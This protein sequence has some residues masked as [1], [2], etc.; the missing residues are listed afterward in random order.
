VRKGQCQGE[1]HSQG[2]VWKVG[3][4]FHGY[5]VGVRPA[6]KDGHLEIYFCQHK[7][8]TLNLNDPQ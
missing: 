1:L 8:A 2:R 7:I 6:D 4:A 5:P 3:K